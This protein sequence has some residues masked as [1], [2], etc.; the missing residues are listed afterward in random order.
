MSGLSPFMGDTDAETLTNVQLAEWDFDDPVFD[1]VSEEAKDFISSL[2]VL[3]ASKR[4]T[5]DQ[6]LKHHWFTVK[7]DKGKKLKTDRLKAFTARRKWK[8]AITA[9]RSTNF[10]SRILGSRGSDDKKGSGGAGGGLLARVKAMHAAGMQG[11]ES[12]VPPASSPFL[13]PASAALSTSNSFTTI[14][15]TERMQSQGQEGTTVTKKETVTVTKDGETTVEERKTTT[16]RN[17][18]TTQQ[19]SR[20]KVEEDENG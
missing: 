12:G 8:R 4:G 13:S 15:V 9:I 10:L 11:S 5:V 3:R 14:T 18:E 19:E 2:L 20:I 16:T 7:K 17:G 6:L 1:D